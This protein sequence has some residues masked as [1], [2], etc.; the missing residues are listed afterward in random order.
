MPEKKDIEQEHY[1]YNRVRFSWRQVRDCVEGSNSVKRANEVYLPMPSGM[2]FNQVTT[3]SF[4]NEIGNFSK[5]TIDYE[6]EYL[7]WEH[8]NPA[9]SAYLQRA[10][11][12]EMTGHSLLGFVGIATRQEPNIELPPG[13]EYL[14]ETATPDGLTLIELFEFCVSEI[15]QTGKLSLVLSIRPEDNTFYIAPYVAESNTDWYMDYIKGKRMQT[16]A[17]FLE[18]GGGRGIAHDQEP[19]E[20]MYYFLAPIEDGP[21]DENGEPELFAHTQF[22]VD[23]NPV[24]EPVLLTSQGTALDQLPIVNLGS[25]KNDPEPDG[26]PLLGISDIALTIFR[27]DA[28][29]AQAQYLTCNPTLFVFGINEQDMPRTVGSTVVVGIPNPNGR[30]EYPATDTSALEHIREHISDLKGEAVQYGANL[31]GTNKRQAESAEALALRKASNGA[32]LVTVARKIGEGITEILNLAARW[33]GQPETALFEPPLDFAEHNLSAQ[34]L[35]SLVR[36]WVEGA[37]SQ[38]TLLDNLRDA[39]IVDNAV[40]NETEKEKIAIEQEN[41]LQMQANA[42][43]MARQQNAPDEEEEEEDNQENSEDE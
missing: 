33:S 21:L 38:D 41:R 10:R 25:I 35:T 17:T 22:F 16:E 37:I 43:A 4:D 15:F 9:Y 8:S 7:P 28:D 2:S 24:G 19:S 40:D 42:M 39:D 27:K 31:L 29:L 20:Y 32:S 11:F 1:K 26:I 13:L 18:S 12:P 30:A 23:G 34:E 6:F 14:R 5:N 3:P 36:S